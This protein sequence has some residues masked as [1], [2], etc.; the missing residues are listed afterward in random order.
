MTKE[1]CRER[2]KLKTQPRYEDFVKHF[3]LSE[4]QKIALKQRLQTKK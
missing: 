2:Q 3:R 4:E 1:F